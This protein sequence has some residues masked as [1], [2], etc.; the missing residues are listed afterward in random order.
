[1]TSSPD[2]RWV[3]VALA[4]LAL[5][6]LAGQGEDPLAAAQTA[7]AQGDG[8]AAEAAARRAL[9]EG[10]PREAVAAYMGEALVLQ[11]E[12]FKALTWLEP[13][14]FDPASAELGFR[15]LGRLRT[16]RGEFGE[17]AEA[18]D[19]ALALGNASAGLWV[20][21]AGLRYRSGEQTIVGDAISRALAIDPR[22]PGALSLQAQL[23]RDSRGLAASLPW[24]EKAVEGAPDNVPLL[25]D[26]AAVLG[27]LGEYR[28][29]LAVVRR[30]FEIDPGESR[31][32]FFQAVLAARAGQDN[33]ARRLLTRAGD[34]ATATPAGLLLAGVLEYRTGN[35]ALAA[36]RFVELLRRQPDNRTAQHLLARALLA[37]G[38]HP[39]V[40]ARLREEAAREEVSPYLLTVLARAYEQTGRREEAALLL[41]RAA[42]AG[43]RALL[44]YPLS[45][46]DEARLAGG[47]RPE[48]AVLRLRH[49][50][51]TARFAEASLFAADLNRSY[52]RSADI[53]ALS[54]DAALLAGEYG[55]ALAAYEAAGQVRRTSG[56]TERMVVAL[57]MTGDNAAADR[58]LVETLQRNP[59]DRQLALLLGRRRADQGDWAQAALLLGQ[60]ARRGGSRDPRLLAELSQA[61]LRAGDPEGALA[62]ARRAYAVQPLRA[63]TAAALAAAMSA[64][65]EAGA[66]V[67][68]AKAG[69]LQGGPA[70]ARR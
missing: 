65:G 33:L 18:F 56:M 27:E 51:G 11:G 59:Q 53:K 14:A 45:V 3:A 2:R 37:A 36:E 20:D 70:L 32:Y 10:A 22:D 34:E 58:L 5:P 69:R 7:L 42:K 46:T 13:G 21:I 15:A 9:A 67:I 57:R 25:A 48:A 55:A 41:D 4:L 52:P 35:P 49:L 31:I 62:S 38:D 28:A 61:Q 23:V 16:E 26:Y 47:A 40:V 29:M 8:I 66:D 30:M 44:P 63:E 6:A 50:V 39:E 1:M 60:A 43:A 54:G 24:F 64:S 68:L 19:R 17:A 12:Q